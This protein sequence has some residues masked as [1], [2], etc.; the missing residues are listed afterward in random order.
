MKLS[1]IQGHLENL[2]VRPSKSLGQNF[3]HD[4]NLAA[5]MV[6]QLDLQSDDH[7]VEIG[8]GLGALTEFAS[9]RCRSMTLIEK[10]ARLAEFL[11]ERFAQ[12]SV[13]VINGDALE[14]D[15]RTLFPRRPVKLIGNLPYYI[16]SPFLFCFTAEPCPMDRLVITIQRELAERLAAKPRTKAY[17]ALTLIIQRRWNVRY[18]RTLPASVFMPVPGVESA[19]LILEPR[20][21][22][23]LPDCDGSFFVSL[24]KQGFS[25]RRKQL[26]KLIGAEDWPRI[27]GALDFSETARAEELSLAQWIALTNERRP[28][29]GSAQE[30]HAEIFDVVDESNRVIHQAT[31]HEVHTQRLLHRAVHIFVFNRAGELFLQKRSRWKDAH[32]GRWDSSAAGHVEAGGDYAETAARELEEELGVQAPTDLIGAIGASHKTGWEFIEL[33]RAHHDGPMT[34]ASSEIECGEFF[35][36]SVIAEWIASRPDDF[37][38]GFIECFKKF[39]R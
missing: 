18:L 37:A 5:W 32:P 28:Q 36:V 16:T 7:L 10:D 4:Q 27:A 30:V 3:L 9:P 35:P 33:F 19:V 31:R 2:Q 6:D 25:Q 22:G 1:E 24:V 12:T 26:R 20:K 38:T 17:G 21:V 29:T 34:L 39:S 14:F 23:E 13:E 8:P 11:R 15:V